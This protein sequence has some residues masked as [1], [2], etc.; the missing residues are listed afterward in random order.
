MIEQLFR[1]DIYGIG[2][3]RANRNQMPKMI[4]DKQMKRGDYEFLLSGNT[5]TCKWMDNR[6]VLLLSSVLEGMNNILTVDW[7]EKG[8]KTKSSVPCLWFD[9][10]HIC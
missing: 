8:S 10:Y 2:A 4:D 1:E 5:V 6:S 9:G 7:R 3:V